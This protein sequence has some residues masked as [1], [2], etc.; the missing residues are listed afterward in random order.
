M[1][2][3]IICCI[4]MG[5]RQTANRLLRR[6]AALGDEG[7]TI[8]VMHVIENIP[9]RHLTDIPEEF[10]TAAIID[11]ERKLAALCKELDV[12]AVIEVRV[13]V[14]ASLLVSAAR[15]RAADLILLSSHVPDI[16]DYVFSSIVG[17][18]VRH[19][20]CSVLID[21]RLDHAGEA[22]AAQTEGVAS[23]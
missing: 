13:G 17:K 18:V 10:E 15:E 3:T 22:S 20:G 16:T 23:L 19:A 4:G 2:R 8:V 14:A 1:Y 7:G 6:A 9:H 21:R 12:P 11:A 5:S